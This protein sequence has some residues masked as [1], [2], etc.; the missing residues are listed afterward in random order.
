MGADAPI[1]PVGIPA[2]APMG[3]CAA[4]SMS[5]IPGT[6]I[7]PAVPREG[8]LAAGSHPLPLVYG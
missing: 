2:A 8:R 7:C 5:S 3:A 6:V 4:A 1:P